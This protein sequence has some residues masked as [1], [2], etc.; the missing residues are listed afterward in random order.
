MLTLHSMDIYANIRRSVDRLEKCLRI[1]IFQDDQQI[2]EYLHK[3]PSNGVSTFHPFIATDGKWYAMYS[4]HYTCTSIMALPS[5]T[6][7]AGEEPASGGFWP[8]QYFVPR[9]RMLLTK[10]IP[11]SDLAQYPESNWSW[12]RVDRT[13]REY[14]ETTDDP[15]QWFA[16]SI[17]G[18]DIE[19]SRMHYLPGVHY[20]T[21]GFVAGCIWGDDGDLKIECFDL[22]DVPS[23]KLTRFAPFGY[24]RMPDHL[25]LRQSIKIADGNE[26]WVTVAT[27]TSFRMNGLG[28][29]E[30]D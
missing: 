12:L 22:S 30:E 11:E 18:G 13:E 20:D 5:C 27:Q 7:V 1:G 28:I 4:E 23:G 9:Y 2:G 10:A 6:K 19:D 21:R 3:Y 16:D 17:K 15:S 25:T 14:E 8:V 26:Q 29:A 24:A